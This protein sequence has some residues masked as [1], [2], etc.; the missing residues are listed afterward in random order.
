MFGKKTIKKEEVKPNKVSSN[1]IQSETEKLQKEY[2]DIVEL[3]KIKNETLD[4]KN[5]VLSVLEEDIKTRK[6]DKSQLDVDISLKKTKLSNLEIA[7]DNRTENKDKLISDI[8][9][10]RKDSA[11]AKTSHDEKV[12]EYVSAIGF[13]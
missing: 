10:L 6:E 1:H 2:N 13:K 5:N 8:E 9:N 4:E 12:S 11:D 3:L 7:I